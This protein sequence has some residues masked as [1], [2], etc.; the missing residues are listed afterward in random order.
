MSRVKPV[1]TIF[2]NCSLV[3][4]YGNKTL[5]KQCCSRLSRRWEGRNTS[6]PKDACVGGC[7]TDSSEEKIR[8]LPAGVETTTF[9]L[10]VQMLYH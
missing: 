9:W 4:Y 5:G 7:D 6:S 1:N 8:V 10:L 2:Q 3:I